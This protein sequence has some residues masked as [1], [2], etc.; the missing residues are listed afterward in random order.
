MLK[1][2]VLDPSASD[3][4]EFT[5]LFWKVDEGEPVSAGEELVV[6]ESSEE[7]TAVSVSAPWD[8]TLAEIVAGEDS[9]VGPGAVLARMETT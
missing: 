7:K 1:D 4:E 5:V 8:G 6:L 9:R 3:A 2:I